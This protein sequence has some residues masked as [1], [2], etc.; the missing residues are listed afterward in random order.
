MHA[1][2]I[3]ILWSMLDAIERD[4]PDDMPPNERP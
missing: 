3:D 1:R 2:K 4:F